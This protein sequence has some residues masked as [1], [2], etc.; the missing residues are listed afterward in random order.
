M[1]VI[2]ANKPRVADVQVR[3]TRSYNQRFLHIDLPKGKEH[4]AIYYTLDGSTPHRSSSRYTSPV[5]LGFDI[6]RI[7]VLLDG[8]DGGGLYQYDASSGCTSRMPSTGHTHQL[9]PASPTPH[10]HHA[11]PGSPT[12]PSSNAECPACGESLIINGSSA[13]C[14]VC[15]SLFSLIHGRWQPPLASQ[16]ASVPKRIKI[17]P[18]RSMPVPA[19]LPDIQPARFDTPSTPSMPEYNPNE[20][21]GS[22]NASLM[23]IAYIVLIG[24]ILL[25][26][27]VTYALGVVMFKSSPVISISFLIFLCIAMVRGVYRLFCSIEA[28][29]VIPSKSYEDTARAWKAQDFS[30][31]V[32]L[33]SQGVPYA[34]LLVGLV[35]HA[36]DSYPDKRASLLRMLTAVNTCINDKKRYRLLNCTIRCW[37]K[38]FDVDDLREWL[39]GEV[40]T[41]CPE[42][43]K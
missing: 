35:L 38:K 9:P 25:A 24:G 11:S 13:R 33:D 28:A 23:L 19:H 6:Q 40:K 22:Y 18:K 26:L 1:P 10:T 2:S 43:H 39:A 37:S 16:Q 3:I 12:N 32:E 17:L 41:H 31:L 21:G 8:A 14:S 15:G 7:M 42:L 29:A 27:G 4:C 20:E 36:S 30:K 34:Q 5:A